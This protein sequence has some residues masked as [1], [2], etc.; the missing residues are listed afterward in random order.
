[1]N[2]GVL[3]YHRV[4]NLGSVVQTWA[5]VQIARMLFPG[6]RVE[7]VDYRPLRMEWREVRKLVRLRPPSVNVR[8]IQKLRSLR[9]FLRRTVTLS[10][11]S[12]R[13]NCTEKAKRW[14]LRQG[15]DVILVGSDTVWELRQGAY[16]PE[17]VNLYF[18][19]G[20]L[21]ARKISI[22]ASMDPVGI[23]NPVQESLMRSR[24]SSLRDFDLLTVRDVVTQRVLTNNGIPSSHV[25]RVPDPTVIV[26]IDPLCTANPPFDSGDR[27][28]AGVSLPRHLAEY[29]HRNLSML[30]YD[31]WDW[32]G[33]VSPFVNRALPG[34]VTP[35][36]LLALHREC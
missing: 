35:E 7:V 3:T 20:N 22:A 14:L 16:S 28:V 11:E 31:V 12:I 30:G 1:M 32:N 25:I 36:Q 34:T 10:N 21:G 19:P 33:V 29:A 27:P 8:Q 23:L 18:L 4:V 9:S 5:T 26:G 13:T 15:Y 24:I 2:V 17:G 6:A